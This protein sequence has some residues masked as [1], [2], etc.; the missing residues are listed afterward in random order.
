[1]GENKSSTDPAEGAAERAR[2]AAGARDGW[3]DLPSHVKDTFRS[4]GRS[5]LPVRHRDWIDEYYRKLNRKG[6][7]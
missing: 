3:G 6:D 7:R 2:Q 4:Q 5:E 1:M